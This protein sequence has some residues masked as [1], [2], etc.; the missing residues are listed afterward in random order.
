MASR[1]RGYWCWAKHLRAA[2][3]AKSELIWK[4][5]PWAPEEMKPH[6]C[7]APHMLNQNISPVLS[8]LLAFTSWSCLDPKAS[9]EKLESGEKKRE[10]NIH[11]AVVRKVVWRITLTRMT[12]HIQHLVWSTQQG[13]L[14]VQGILKPKWE[15]LRQLRW[16]SKESWCIFGVSLMQ[17]GTWEEMWWLVSQRQR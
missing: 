6:Q 3:G 4:W 11:A 10:L 5:P 8:W 16:Q 9:T 1:S 2:L 7:T 14:S 13:S 12:Q 15:R 17:M